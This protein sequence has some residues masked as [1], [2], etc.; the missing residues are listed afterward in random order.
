[1]N[2]VMTTTQRLGIVG[3]AIYRKHMFLIIQKVVLFIYD[4]QGWYTVL[5]FIFLMML[6]IRFVVIMTIM[7][8]STRSLGCSVP[9]L[10]APAE[11]WGPLVFCMSTIKNLTTARIHSG[12]MVMVIYF[13]R[14]TM[15]AHTEK[16]P[17]HTH[18]CTDLAQAIV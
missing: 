13:T 1:M 14:L 6:N 9:L 7:I 2:S 17:Q 15:T 11:G 4:N 16:C 5:M 3:L 18:S 8:Y 12:I 10:L